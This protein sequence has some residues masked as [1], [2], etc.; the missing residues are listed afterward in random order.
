MPENNLIEAIK[1][2]S[3]FLTDRRK[4]LIEDVLSKRTRHVTVVLEDV[5]KAQNASA[6]LRTCECQGIQDIHI[7]ENNHK[8]DVNPDVVKGATKW[9]SINKYL[10]NDGVNNTPVC[11][12][13]LKAKGYKVV[14]VDPRGKKEIEDLPIDEPLAIVFGTEYYGLSDLARQEADDLVAIP[15]FGFTQSYNLSVSAALCLQSLTSRL[16]GSSVSW[17]IPTNESNLLKLEWY[18]GQVRDADNM[19][20]RHFKGQKC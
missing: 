15:M 2:L 19:L 20:S 7:I 17:E 3:Q 6:V 5:F 9:L 13:H 10:K 14:A 18:K 16:R 1:F 4:D 12:S 8:Y 11:F